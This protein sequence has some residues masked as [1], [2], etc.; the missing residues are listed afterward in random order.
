MVRKGKKARALP[1]AGFETGAG[2]SQPEAAT[3]EGRGGVATGDAKRK[4]AAGS[5]GHEAV[6]RKKAGRGRG[7]GGAAARVSATV[8]EDPEEARDEEREEEG[9]GV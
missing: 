6:D 4:G 3:P 8:R 5:S 2:T 9:Q 1:G 7:D